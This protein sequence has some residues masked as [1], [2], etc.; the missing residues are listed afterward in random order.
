M[1]TGKVVRG[2]MGHRK[3]VNCVAASEDGRL[4]ITGSEDKTIKIWDTSSGKC[5]DTLKGHHTGIRSIHFFDE[6]K[7]L[8]AACDETII[9][10]SIGS[11][12]KANMIWSAEEFMK[13]TLK[14]VPMWHI[15]ALG[16]GTPKSV[17]RFFL[18]KTFDEGTPRHIAMSYASRSPSF[19]FTHRGFL[20]AGLLPKPMNG[21]PLTASGTVTVVAISSDGNWAATADPLGALQIVDLSVP[22]RSWDEL[23]AAAKADPLRSADKVIPSLTGTRFIIDTLIQQF[24]VDGDHRIVKRF[25]WSV[26]NTLRDDDEHVRFQF[27]ADGHAMFSIASSRLMSGRSTLRV[28]DTETGAQRAQFSGLKKVHGSIASADGAWIACGHGQGQVD[29]LHVQGGTRTGMRVP[30][31]EDGKAGANK[32]G[33][34]GADKDAED[35]ASSIGVFVFSDDRDARALVG[36][37]RAGTVYVWDRASGA[38]TA[39][40][41]SAT[42]P[43]TALG[44]WATK[45]T[46]AIG[47]ADGSLSMW[48]PSTSASYDLVR[49]DT[50]PTPHIDV[51]RFSEDAPEGLRLISR[52]EDGA[53]CRWAVSVPVLTADRGDDGNDGHNEDNGGDSGNPGDNGN[54][55]GEGE[56]DN[57]DDGGNGTDD[58]NDG[59]GGNDGDALTPAGHVGDTHT[60]P[61]TPSH[62][63]AQTHTLLTRSDPAEA[64]DSHFHTAYR[65]RKDGWLV[66]GD[67]RRVWMPPSIRP[68]GKDVVYAYASGLIVFFTPS[69]L[70]GFLKLGDERGGEPH[71]AL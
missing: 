67:R 17:M 20:Y 51:A 36:G 54:D 52:G 56:G 47:R 70:L 71:V 14:R 41:R 23:E 15:K 49:A 66:Q 44:Y 43:V 30:A 7:H 11:R 12:N 69:G 6:D 33:K 24:L 48:S 13:T 27:C 35:S 39:T 50:A 63:P 2:M 38:C 1:S 64:P 60:P 18:T 46:I 32:D 16:W 59:E 53:V 62:A 65:V 42:S 61:Q 3:A 25:D 28:F 34:A 19:V 31:P 22:G 10:W 40:C 29:V 55:R 21:V 4:L 45:D 5:T 9:S 37:S 26:L 57:G 68:R 8:V 58:G